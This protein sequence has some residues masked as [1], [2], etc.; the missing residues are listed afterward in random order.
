[1][2]VLLI[3][4]TDGALFRFR[5]PIIRALTAQ[6]HSIVSLSSR[7]HY[8]DAL[9]A[10]GVETHELDF[11]R[12][13]YSVWR[14]LWLG[15]RILRFIRQ[16]RP[17]IVH[18]FTHKPA[19]FGSLAA[20]FCSIR[21]VFVT[22]TGLGSVFSRSGPRTWLLRQA[23]LAQY[24]IALR[25]VDRVYFQNPDD[26]AYFI[27]H[28]IVRKEKAVLTHGSGIDLKEYPL[29]SAAER[30]AC[31]RGLS[32]EVGFDLG[33]RRVVLFAARG[34]PEKGLF[35]FYEASRLVNAL[36]PEKYAFVHLGLVDAD[37][38]GFVDGDTV[39]HFARQNGV[40]Y[41]GFREDMVRYMTATDIVVLPS[42]YREGT[43]RVLIEALALGKV[44]VTTDMPGCKETVI[45]G[46]NGFLC[47][48][49]DARSLASN[50]LAIDD[51]M[52]ERCRT[53]S[54]RLC[55]RKYDAAELTALTLRDYELAMQ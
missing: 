47:A 46:W 18:S 48:P 10:L 14:N 6:R 52:I 55:E 29:L 41:L 31:R 12:H 16:E 25:T 5:K 7:S 4:N 22:I 8:F 34:I 40:A 23:M 2:K 27:R 37:A 49:R 20:R 43:P 9:A 45:D 17:D 35:E 11:A 19:I 42:V 21:G 38:S 15:I 44:V 33:R 24:R 32:A 36:E 30:E 26:M 39:A 13:S 54:R 50:I 51:E 28:R 1:M 53:R 3:V